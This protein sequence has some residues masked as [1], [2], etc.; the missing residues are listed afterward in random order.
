MRSAL[1]GGAAAVSLALATML[2]ASTQPQALTTPDVDLAALIIHGTATNPTGDAMVDIF[3]GE[4]RHPADGGFLYANYLGGP[5]GL[6]G[7]MQ[8]NAEEE[9]LTIGDGPGDAATLA[10][11]LDSTDQSGNVF[12]INYEF[13]A[14]AET[15]VLNVFADPDA[16]TAHDS[17]PSVDRSGG[18]D[19]TGTTTCRTDPRTRI[20]T[21]TYPDGVVAVVE[22]I[23]DIT[24]VTYRMLGAAVLGHLDTTRS[25]A[26]ASAPAPV[27]QPTP[28]PSAAE[29]PA[30]TPADPPLA[31]AAA[32]AGP[33]LNVVRPAPDFTPGRSAAPTSSSGPQPSLSDKA[34]TLVNDVL[35]RVSDTVNNTLNKMFNRGAAGSG[36]GKVATPTPAGE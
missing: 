19:C 33:R 17:K 31:P 18:V 29:P 7:A 36:T 3:D 14:R 2:L 20:T 6:Y 21:L 11:L 32:S 4:F 13:D 28:A 26:P 22:R 24:V 30:P 16:L 27:P 15:Q 10:E 8:G 9:V 1:R 5:I 35:T 25:E 12:H 34:D 23:D